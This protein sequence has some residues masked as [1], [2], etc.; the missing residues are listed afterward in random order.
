MSESI[1]QEN[2]AA[3][4]AALLQRGA[5]AELKLLRAEQRAERRLQDAVATF[6]AH[7]SKLRKAEA[8]VAKSRLSVTRAESA[9]QDRQRKRAVGPVWDSD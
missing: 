6:A 1:R 9:L 8:R 2:G 5:S 3:E 7:E 4:A